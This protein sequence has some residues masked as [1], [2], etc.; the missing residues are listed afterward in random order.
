MDIEVLGPPR[1]TENGVPIT[2]PTPESRHVLAVLAACP[3]RVVPVSVL[4]GELA[5]RVP[6]E[7][8]REVLHTAVRRLR[9]RIAE[10]LGPS[11]V[12][13]PETVLSAR[14]GGYLLDTGGGRCDVREFEREAGAG[15]RALGRGDAARA[16]PR[17]RG[18]LDLWTGPALD[19]IAAGTWLRGR[20]AVL[21]ADRLSVLG[22]WVEAELALGRHRELRLALAGLRGA[23]AGRPGGAYLA[24][25]RR[26]EER[27]L[28]PR[29]APPGP[30]LGPLPALACA[31]RP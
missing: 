9:E 27:A 30:A 1:V 25:L 21:D 14:P 10:A 3:D 23:G 26:A 12:R 8:T 6:P 18:A 29:P 20:I 19:G 7:H 11:S 16:A 31:T 13:T 4:A 28:T 2:A 24:A 15:Y 22:Q 5:G 17:L